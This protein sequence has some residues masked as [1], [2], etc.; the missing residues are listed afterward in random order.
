M[1][2]TL[3]KIS[4]PNLILAGVLLAQLIVIVI[5]FW[6]RQT[7]LAASHLLFPGL[8]ADQV[9]RI[10]IRD[11]DGNVLN[12]TKKG[13]DWVLPDAD[14]FPATQSRVADFLAKLTTMKADKPVTEQ[15]VSQR[16]LKVTP[17][18]YMRLVEFETADGKQTRF[19][20]GTAPSYSTVHFRMD[21]DKQVFRAA[22]MPLSDSDP[23]ITS[24]V[25][26]QHLSVPVDQIT[27]LTIT[28]KNGTLEFSRDANGAWTLKGLPAGQT[29][30]DS[31]MATIAN[32]VASVYLARP[33]GKTEKPAYGMANPNAVVVFTGKDKEGKETTYTLTVGAANSTDNTY[34][35][36]TSNSPYYI[37]V[38]DYGV[39]EMINWGM[40]DYIKQPTPT[41]E[42]TGAAK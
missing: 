30:D 41:P 20:V 18:D 7:T 24:W 37:A 32:R 36:L 28:N 6:P 14:D 2:T 13:Q 25:N 23:R 1:M 12:L 5:V 42:A 3:K 31:K 27:T 39:T 21:G 17:D 40:Q 29:L 8:T 34:V 9:V 10:T 4:R 16:R 15:E 22:G 38:A 26:T 35:V 33:L 11:G 19:Y